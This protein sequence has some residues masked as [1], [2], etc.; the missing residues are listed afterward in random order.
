MMLL[1]L[2]AGILTAC[3][4]D[5]KD[6]VDT[7]ESRVT[8]LEQQV[9]ENVDAIS[10]LV[11]ANE[12]AVTVTSVVTTENG[13][14][15][16][17]SDGNKVTISNGKDGSIVGVKEENGI[18]Y[19]T[20]NGEFLLNDGA[21][22][23]VSGADGVTPQF[24]VEDGKWYVSYGDGKWTL[25]GDAVTVVESKVTVTETETD[26]VFNIDGTQISIPKTNVFAIRLTSE[27]TVIV[28]GQTVNIPY[29]ITG[30][31]E[32]THVVAEAK[33]YDVRVDEASRILVVTAPDPLVDGYVIVKAIRNSDG[34]YSAQYVV[35]DVQEYGSNGSNIWITDDSSY[36]DW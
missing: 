10:K 19:W 1:S 3:T 8:A 6:R 26:F 11:S 33:N 21:K 35:F 2:A 7:L 25:V 4:G 12:K 14:V 17:F 36:V 29:T 28:S 15:I 22:V 5:L 30:S 16:T 23:P 27:K 18:L 13:Y 20:V 31:D 9:Q 24:K 32:T 34:A